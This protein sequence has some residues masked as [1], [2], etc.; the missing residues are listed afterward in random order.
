VGGGGVQLAQLF[1]R[2]PSLTLPRKRGREHTECAARLWIT[3]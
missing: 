2:A 1:L 3:Q